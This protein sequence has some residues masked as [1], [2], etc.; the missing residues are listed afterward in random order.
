MQLIVLVPRVLRDYVAQLP[1]VQH[2]AYNYFNYDNRVVEE[3]VPRGDYRAPYKNADDFTNADYDALVSYAK[4]IVNPILAK[5]SARVAN[6]DAM[7]I[8]VRSFDNGLFDGKVNANKFEVLVSA[9]AEQDMQVLLQPIQQQDVQPVVMAAMKS[10][11]KEKPSKPVTRT[12]LKQLGLEPHK[13]P[14]RSQIRRK[15]QKGIP[16]LV[17]NPG[18]GVMV[19]K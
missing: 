19:E 13:V 9:M 11:K 18:K 4:T 8:A 10:K 14:L 1:E 6:E 3:K 2:N 7:N 17:R 16:H 12:V 15:I 5:Y